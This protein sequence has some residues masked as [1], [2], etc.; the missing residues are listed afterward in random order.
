MYIP[1]LVTVFVV[2]VDND[3]KL[4]VI[5]FVNVLPV[6]DDNT[7]KEIVEPELSVTVEDPIVVI[8]LFVKTP[9]T[10]SVD[11][12]TEVTPDILTVPKELIVIPAFVSAVILFPVKV[13]PELTVSN[14]FAVV[15]N[16]DARSVMVCPVSTVS[17]P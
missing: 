9:E 7:G 11:P 6:K 2:K 16:D 17:L 12:V 4:K 14:A 13:P 8:T 1:L 15:E 5:L 10:A 3:G